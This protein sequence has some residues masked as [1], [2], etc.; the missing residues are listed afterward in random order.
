MSAAYVS[1][2]P[3]GSVNKETITDL[4][5]TYAA[6]VLAAVAGL[7]VA[8]ALPV[9]LV[10]FVV[11]GAFTLVALLLGLVHPDDIRSAVKIARST[12]DRASNVWRTT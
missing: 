5:R 7:K 10:F 11:T 8:A 12:V 9:V 2:L 6:A 1:V 3:R 4:M